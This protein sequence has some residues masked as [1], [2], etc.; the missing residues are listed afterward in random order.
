MTS[1]NIRGSLLETSPLISSAK[2]T[3]R[4]LMVGDGMGGKEEGML[5][6]KGD[7]AL[8]LCVLL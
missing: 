2:S 7:A 1:L 6:A 3:R 4:D 5:V 8:V